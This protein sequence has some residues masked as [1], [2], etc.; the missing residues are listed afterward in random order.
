MFGYNPCSEPETVPPDAMSRKAKIRCHYS[1]IDRKGNIVFR[2]SFVDAKPFSEGLAP[3]GDGKL[4]GYVDTAGVLRIR[5][6]F[7]Q[8]EPFY[9]GL[10]RVELNNKSGF[11]DKAGKIAIAPQFDQAYDFAEG[12]AV[13]VILG[14]DGK[15]KFRFIDHQGKQAIAGEFAAASNFVM[16][17]AHVQ[18]SDGAQPTWAYIEQSG[19]SI[20]KY[21]YRR[22]PN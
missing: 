2:S 10:A 15:K 16:G 14:D 1:V 5:E 19:K 13:V 6:Q 8:A 7:H 21:T 9:E 4:W 18:L 17:L 12:L 3:V 11:I 20:F 22:N